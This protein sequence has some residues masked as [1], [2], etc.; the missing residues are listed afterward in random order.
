VPVSPSTRHGNRRTGQHADG[1]RVPRHPGDLRREQKTHEDPTVAKVVLGL[2]QHRRSPCRLIRFERDGRVVRRSGQ[3][4][5]RIHTILRVVR[6]RGFTGQ[7][8][9]GDLNLSECAAR[10]VLPLCR[11]VTPLS[12]FPA[13]CT[14][15]L[16]ECPPPGAGA[17]TVRQHGALAAAPCWPF[18]QP[19][20]IGPLREK[21]LG[22]GASPPSLL[23]AVCS[24]STIDGIKAYCSAKRPPLA[25]P[26]RPRLIG[27]V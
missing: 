27:A 8:S 24:W 12:G 2:C 23:R 22:R 11:S 21:E 1:P 9:A 5:R 10:P 4:Y 25:V 26:G 18:N 16:P 6:S 15:I 19:V 17:R 13:L 3:E 7:S 20:L 14:R